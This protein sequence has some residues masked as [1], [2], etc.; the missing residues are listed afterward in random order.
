MSPDDEALLPDNDSSFGEPL[1]PN[2]L[3]TTISTALPLHTDYSN[4]TL[5]DSESG[6]SGTTAPSLVQVKPR[7]QCLPMMD[8][9]CKQEPEAEEGNKDD[10]RKRKLTRSRSNSP[11]PINKKAVFE[12]SPVKRQDDSVCVKKGDPWFD[13]KKCILFNSHKASYHYKALHSKKNKKKLTHLSQPNY[14]SKGPDLK[15]FTRLCNIFIKGWRLSKQ[16]NGMNQRYR[17]KFYSV[18]TTTV[19]ALYEKGLIVV[20]G[21]ES[22]L[23]ITKMICTEIRQDNSK[24]IMLAPPLLSVLVTEDLF[25]KYFNNT[26][27][28]GF[29]G[30]GYRTMVQATA[31]PG[32]R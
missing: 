32:T 24:L 13:V 17:L 26:T 18:L 27:P 14:T 30:C 1:A 15:L 8:D 12:I 31:G 11:A 3:G 5:L 29:T 25:N 23:N 19:D 9:T 6:E 7:T 10:T 20:R 28:N 4:L 22:E 2:E 21:P 16:L